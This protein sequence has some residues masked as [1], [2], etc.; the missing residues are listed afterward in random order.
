[1]NTI[2]LTPEQMIQMRAAMRKLGRDHEIPEI[3]G[4]HADEDL[5]RAIR[6]LKPDR[7]DNIDADQAEELCAEWRHG[8]YSF[9]ANHLDHSHFTVILL[10]PEVENSNGPDSWTTSVKAGD[11]KEAIAKARAA[12]MVHH[13]PIAAP[14]DEQGSDGSHLHVIAVIAGIHTDIKP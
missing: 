12:Y 6:H 4:C 11:T 5:H 1:M 10:Y 2:K 8:Y 14:L 13:H 3:P 7:D 9:H